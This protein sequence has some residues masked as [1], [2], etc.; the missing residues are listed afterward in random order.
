MM[1]APLLTRDRLVVLSLR[2]V[3]SVVLLGLL[4]IGS[5]L[6]SIGSNLPSI[7]SNLPSI[8]SKILASISTNRGN[9]SASGAGDLGVVFT[10]VARQSGL[11]A[12]TI[13]G[14]EHRN[15]YLLETTGCG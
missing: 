12:R 7:G 10:N 15:R 11:T 1:Q 6:P 13:Y 8:G 4:P 3:S 5:N 2:C 14:D 9:V